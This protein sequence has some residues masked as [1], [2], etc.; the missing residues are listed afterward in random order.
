MNALQDAAHRA[1]RDHPA[2]LTELALMEWLAADGFTLYEESRRRRPEEL[3][4]AHFL[5]FHALYRLRLEQAGKANVRIHCL[6]IALEPP[7]DDPPEAG[8]IADHDALAA[9]YLD[10]DQLEGMDDDAVERLIQEGLDRIRGHGERSEALEIL[11]L[12]ANATPSEV[13]THYR[14]LAMQY[15][16]DRGGDTETLQRINEAYASLRRAE[17]SG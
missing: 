11:G 12:D 9:Y 10:L 15:H 17:W 14:R 7:G 13:R 16:P 1:L 4:R 6:D 8:A 5:L 2:G 3:F